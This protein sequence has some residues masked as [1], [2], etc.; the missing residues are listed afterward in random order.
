MSSPFSIVVNGPTQSG[1]YDFEIFQ[2]GELRLW[3][4]SLADLMCLEFEIGRIKVAIQC[5]HSTATTNGSTE[6]QKNTQHASEPLRQTSQALFSKSIRRL[7]GE[8]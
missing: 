2:R 1:V 8:P 3:D 5:G 4:L 7:S 6:T